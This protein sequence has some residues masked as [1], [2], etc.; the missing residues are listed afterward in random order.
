[1]KRLRDGLVWLVT[2]FGGGGGGEGGIIIY[3]SVFFLKGKGRSHTERGRSLVSLMICCT[4]KVLMSAKCVSRGSAGNWV[5]SAG[6]G[7]TDELEAAE[8]RAW[9]RGPGPRDLF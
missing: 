7:G 2:F 6:D 8:V 1:M 5:D 3:W 4:M 9:V